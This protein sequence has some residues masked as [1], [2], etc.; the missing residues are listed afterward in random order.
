[1]HYGSILVLKYIRKI[2][3]FD[4]SK[5]MDIKLKVRK[6]KNIRKITKVRK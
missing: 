6:I 4:K 5:K 1:M 2:K 3:D